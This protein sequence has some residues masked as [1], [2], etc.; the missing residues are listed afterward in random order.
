MSPLWR[1]R[2]LADTIAPR[3]EATQMMMRRRTRMGRRRRRRTRTNLLL[4]SMIMIHDCW[5]WSKCNWSPRGPWLSFYT[6]IFVRSYTMWTNFYQ[7]YVICFTNCIRFTHVQ[8]T[9]VPG[10]PCLSIYHFPIP[11][12]SINVENQGDNLGVNLSVMR[13]VMSTQAMGLDVT[14][15]MHIRKWIF[16]NWIFLINKVLN[17][18]LI[19]YFWK[20]KFWI[21][22][23]IEFL[24]KNKWMN[25]SL[26][27]YLSFYIEW[28]KKIFIVRKLTETKFSSWRAKP[29]WPKLGTSNLEIGTQQVLGFSW[30]MD[31]RETQTRN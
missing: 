20:F 15:C 26:N 31:Q 12:D 19:E 25:K 2:L 27:Q 18:F 21:I 16:F 23:W 11:V 5:W 4:T 29:L 7:F 13:Q 9:H 8:R 14:E 6:S 22:L 1:W 30:N 28:I 17:I 3:H 10:R 24:P